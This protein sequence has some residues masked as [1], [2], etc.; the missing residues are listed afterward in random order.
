MEG[1]SSYPVKLSVDYP[2]RSLNRATTFFRPFMAIP[3]L[4]II[5]LLVGPQFSSDT[6]NG[7]SWGNFYGA[8]VVVPTVLLILFRKKYPRWWYDWNI[9]MTR[10]GTRILVYFL[11]MTDQYPSTDEDQSV[12]IE[13]PYADAGRS[14]NRW[15]PLVK[16]FL[17][18]P[19]LIVLCFVY[20]AGWACAIVAWFAILFT[21][22]YPKRLFDFQVGIIRWSLRVMAYAFL[23]TTDTYPPFG[24]A[25]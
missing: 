21:G 14:L 23:L 22:R 1:T 18:I 20:I 24:L 7:W 19:H 16:W 17:A 2:D 3:I 25:L 13:I 8:L 15:L 12:H 11:L 5:A 4:I 9:A 6:G 10:F